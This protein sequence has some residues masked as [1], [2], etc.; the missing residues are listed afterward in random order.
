MTHNDNLSVVH[1]LP[2]RCNFTIFSPH[3]Y[4]ST[5]Y[6]ITI[7]SIFISITDIRLFPFFILSEN[8]IFLC[9]FPDI[10]LSFDDSKLSDIKSSGSLQYKIHF[11]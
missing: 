2:V 6:V 11:K 5:V 3:S 8:I 4:Y 7:S 9:K 10:L 1:W